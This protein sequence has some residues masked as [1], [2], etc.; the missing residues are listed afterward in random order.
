M[1]RELL[2]D[3]ALGVL[4][5]LLAYVVWPYLSRLARILLALAGL[6]GCLQH[7]AG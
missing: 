1:T 5:A 4:L 6:F 2:C 3:C 7:C